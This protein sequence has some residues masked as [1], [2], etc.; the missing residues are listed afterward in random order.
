M[1]PGWL[2]WGQFSQVHSGFLQDVDLGL[3][4]PESYFDLWIIVLNIIPVLQGWF[5]FGNPLM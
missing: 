5:I 3:L 4:F 2:F 1:S